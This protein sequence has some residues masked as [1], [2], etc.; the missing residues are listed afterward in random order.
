MTKADHEVYLSLGSNLGEKQGNCER[1]LI[2]L[3]RRGIARV[4]ERSS[5]YRT[6]P[7]DFRDQ[8]WFVNAVA[9]VVT[10]LE[11]EQ[12][13]SALKH[14]ERELG[15]REK[16]VRFG[17]RLIDLDIL[18]YDEGVFQVDGLCI[19]HERM[20]QRAF[21]LVPFCEISP[22]KRHPV[23]KKTMGELLAEINP[24]HQ[25]VTVLTSETG[26]RDD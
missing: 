10:G 25:G 16:S 22:G 15:T 14:L 23:L 20:H 21:V 18:L 11:P 13:L 1:A 3:E 2:E 24:E 19:P 7:V 5:F 6:E 17:P 9:R 12:L 8:D 4:L 26:E